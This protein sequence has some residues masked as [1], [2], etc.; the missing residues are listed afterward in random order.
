MY[1]F[2]EVMDMPT[3]GEQLKALRVKKGMTQEQLAQKLNTTKAAI[4]RYEKNQRQPRLEQISEIAQILGANPDE[5]FNLI[6]RSQEVQDENGEIGKTYWNALCKWACEVMPESVHGTSDY[7]IDEW[8]N[9]ENSPFAFYDLEGE[10]IV[11][12]LI[13]VFLKLDRNWQKEL[14]EDAEMYLEFQ[15]KKKAKAQRLEQE[16]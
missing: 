9:D 1:T 16:G 11:Q 3:L 12:K 7:D 15:E 14:V 10:E 6:F 2:I 13:D 4:S 8:I 5:L